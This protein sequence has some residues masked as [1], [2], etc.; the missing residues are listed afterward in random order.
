MS[1][2]PRLSPSF[3]SRPTDQV[4]RALLG[5]LLVREREGRLQV[6][7]IVETEAYLGPRDKACHTARGRTPRNEAMFGAP[8]L[9]YVYFVYGMHHC[10]NVV[11]GEGEAVLVRALE[12][13]AGLDG[14]RTDGPARLCRELDIDRGLNTH[15]LWAPPLWL[16]AGPASRRIAKGPR[17]GVDYAGA[18]ARRA[19]RFWDQD[20]AHVSR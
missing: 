6:G 4:A 2:Y 12:P 1:G 5:Q 3:F 8:G 18:W 14:A 10:F 15:P 13:L 16:S 9:A 11:T 17:I 19:L 7:R 20:S